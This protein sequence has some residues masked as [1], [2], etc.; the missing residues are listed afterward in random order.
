MRRQLW[1]S[2][3]AI[4]SQHQLPWRFIG[5]YIT[6]LKAREHRGAHSPAR[7]LLLQ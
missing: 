6:I 5:Y 2:L 3:D 4:Q 7:N 1:I